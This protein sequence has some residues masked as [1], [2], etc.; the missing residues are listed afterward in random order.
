MDMSVSLW[1][2]RQEM[3]EKQHYLELS[4]IYWKQ[5]QAHLISVGWEAYART[6]NVCLTDFCF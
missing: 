3:L 1:T 5:N 4:N 6:I 2:D